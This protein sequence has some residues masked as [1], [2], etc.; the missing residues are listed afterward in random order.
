MAYVDDVSPAPVPPADLLG[1]LGVWRE[2]LSLSRRLVQR[3]PEGA[4]AGPYDVIALGKA[5]PAMVEALG[6][7]GV[8]VRRQIVIT[9]A[10]ARR[11]D[12]QDIVGDHPVPGAASEAAARALDEFLREGEAAVPTLVLL[13]GGASALV[14]DVVDPVSLSDLHELWDAA[15]RT[16]VDITTLNR[17]RASASN[18]GGGML[19][20]R[21]RSADSVVAVMVDNP[22]SGPRWVASGPFTDFAPSRAEL[23]GLFEAVALSPRARGVFRRAAAQRAQRLRS[24]EPTRT[25][26]I[27][28]AEPADVLH[29]VRDEAIRLG[30]AVHDLG[31]G[32]VENVEVFAGRV[33]ALLASA[34]GPTVVLGVGELAVR[35]SGPGQ[36][37]RCQEFAL[38]CAA[39]LDEA[40]LRSAVVGAVAT[41][42]RDHV[43]GV[44]GAWVSASIAGEAREAGLSL[45]DYLAR[46]DSGTLL[47]RLGR[48][49][50]GSLTGWNLCDLYLGLVHPRD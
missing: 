8:G 33:G 48:H 39:W 16:G 26:L 14:V 29:S 27:T 11:A 42:G 20:R 1:L 23:D 6:E 37:G 45:V 19:A 49:F 17:L 7:V 40:S 28:L 44:A 43:S 25:R 21:V 13:S 35:V 50:A 38:R 3:W 34:S 36:G 18:L 4:P 41:D 30:Y 47:A 32:L 9:T 22:V 46:S 24:Q 31:A 10:E 15:L 12:S 2:G 5:A